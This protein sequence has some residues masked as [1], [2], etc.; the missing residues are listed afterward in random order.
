MK[1]YKNVENTQKYPKSYQLNIKRVCERFIMPHHVK[2]SLD[3]IV[4]VIKL[5]EM[6]TQHPHIINEQQTLRA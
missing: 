2:A 6:Q 1:T 5:A 4:V 3:S